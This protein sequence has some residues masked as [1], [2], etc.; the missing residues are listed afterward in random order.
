MFGEAPGGGLNGFGGGRGPLALDE[1]SCGIPAPV[2]GEARGG[3]LAGSDEGSGKPAVDEGSCGIPV[4]SEVRS[5]KTDLN[6]G[7]CGGKT[8]GCWAKTTLPPYQAPVVPLSSLRVGPED[9]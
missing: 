9:D 6:E 4:P 7:T 5:G 2:V 3:G 1:G 8:V